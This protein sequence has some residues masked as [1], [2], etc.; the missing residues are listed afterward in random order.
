[1]YIDVYIDV[2]INKGLVTVFFEFYSF[3]VRLNFILYKQKKTIILLDGVVFV[4][5][6]T[7]LASAFCMNSH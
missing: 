1:M 2:N 5:L 3:N 6:T 7:S 4:L